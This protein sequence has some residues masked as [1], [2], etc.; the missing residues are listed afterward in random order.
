[1]IEVVGLTKSYGGKRVVDDLSFTVRPGAVTGFLGPNG[2]GKTT[3]LRMLLGLTRPDS[4]RALIDGRPYH[5]HPEPLRVAGA[6]LEAGW[7]HP[8]RSAR[9]HLTWL[10][11]THR[12]P[13]SRVDEVLAAVGL[14]SVAARRVGT[15][16]LGM[17]QRLGLAAAL[18]GDP[19]LLILDEPV[20]GLDPEGIAWMRTTIRA[21]AAEGRT[22]LVSSHLLAEM[23]LTADE[24]VMIG[25]GRLLAQRSV[26]ELTVGGAVDRSLVRTPEPER[27]RALVARSGGTVTDAAGTPGDSFLV[28]GMGCEDIG[29]AAAQEGLVLYELTPRRATLEDAFLRLT[30][31]SVE[32]R[33]AGTPLPQPPVTSEGAVR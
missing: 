11:H 19:R 18:L 33:G 13:L 9:A 6:L 22:V 30:G 32:F 5:A 2:S 26:A 3:T 17:A 24:L 21:L 20:N 10:A 7:A 25:Q 4:G 29:R 12:I 1:M 15:Y 16:S 28:H 8:K 14:A 27:L 23:A 31:E